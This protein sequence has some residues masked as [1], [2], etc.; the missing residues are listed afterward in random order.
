MLVLFFFFLNP[1]FEN[2]QKEEKKKGGG[3]HK[4]PLNQARAYWGL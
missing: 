4:S 3:A 2:F 1:K